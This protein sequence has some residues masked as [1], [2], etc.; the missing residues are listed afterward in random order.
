MATKQQNANF[1][2]TVPIEVIT[3]NSLNTIL[4][5]TVHV[6]WRLEARTGLEGNR[7]A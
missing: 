4:K 6:G 2:H 7:A 3:M 1:R 5:H